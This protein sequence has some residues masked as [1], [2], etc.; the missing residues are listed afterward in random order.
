MKMKKMNSISD[1][2]NLMT[3]AQLTEL[4]WGE[5][6]N[7]TYQRTLDHLVKNGRIP[8]L[9]IG[10]RYY[11]KRKDAEIWLNSAHRGTSE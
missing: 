1:S 8:S 5:K 9:Q 11:V 4:I 10:Q 6:N 7:A 3:V 2:P